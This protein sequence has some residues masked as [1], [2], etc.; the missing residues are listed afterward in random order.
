MRLLVFAA[1]AVSLCQASQ[2]FL[3]SDLQQQFISFLA[4]YGKVYTSKSD[5]ATRFSIFKQNLEYISKHNEKA[6]G[7]SLGVNRYSDLTTDEF[8]SLYSA[9]T[10]ESNLFLKSSI[11]SPTA[12]LPNNPHQRYED[13]TI[14]T[15]HKDYDYNDYTYIDGLR[16]CKAIDWRLNGKVTPIKTQSPLCVGSSWAFSVAA[17]LESL[18][19]IQSDATS[20]FD[21]IPSFSVQQILDCDF[22]PNMGC[23]GG[24]REHAFKY[25][26]DNGI[27][28]EGN[29]P[30]VS[31]DY[32]KLDCK[33]DATTENAFQITSFKAYERVTTT[34]LE[35]LVCQGPV[36]ISLRI[37]D[38]IKNYHSGII[39]DGPGSDCGCSDIPSTNH[40]A[41]I[42]GFGSDRTV[43]SGCRQFWVVKN[44]WGADWGEEGYL[45]L[46]KEDGMSLSLGTCNLKSEVMIP[47]I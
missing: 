34:D 46:C 18:N 17:T 20:H 38:C 29:Y 27:A 19:A 47:I 31:D 16:S 43:R 44:S 2:K 10:A 32:G 12:R 13:P 41:V 24:R 4:K 28:F 14:Q 21:A 35:T 33:Y 26:Q 40:A 15:S 23:V 6:L 36:S 45:R 30:L 3:E 5:H 25:V 39:F 22:G 8:M 1:A 11:N 7:Y 37:N 9:N 42:V